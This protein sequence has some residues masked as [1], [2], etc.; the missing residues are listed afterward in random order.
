[1]EP[2]YSTAVIGN[3]DG[4]AVASDG[5]SSSGG[6]QKRNGDHIV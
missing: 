1:M 4:A 5:G 3:H 2:G 6:M